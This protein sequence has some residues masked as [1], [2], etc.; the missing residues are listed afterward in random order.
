MQVT[1]PH[2]ALGM[3]EMLLFHGGG[4]G[5]T[6]VRQVKGL[7]QTQR[8]VSAQVLWCFC[9]PRVSSPQPALLLLFRSP[10]LLLGS[11]WVTLT[12]RASTYHLLGRR[13][14]LSPR[15]TSFP[16]CVAICLLDVSTG[17]YHGHLKLNG[18][19]NQASYLLPLCLSSSCLQLL[20]VR[21][22]LSLNQA[23]N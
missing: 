22:Y 7:E 8:T 9:G 11:P 15:L 19:K 10:C 23:R 21:Y 3:C 16:D 18:S 12:P 4:K 6:M 14:S 1:L 20:L 13:L 5:L 17:M 2:C